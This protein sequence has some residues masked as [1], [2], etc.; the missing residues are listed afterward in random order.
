MLGVL[1]ERKFRSYVTCSLNC[2]GKADYDEATNP[3]R[4]RLLLDQR[5]LN[6]FI[7]PPKFSLETLHRARHLFQPGDVALQYDLSAAFYQAGVRQS[8]IS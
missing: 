8:N 4:V 2:I 7:S 3:N 6:A 1:V 5:P